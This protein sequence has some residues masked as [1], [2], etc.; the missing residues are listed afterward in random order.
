M[1]V[2]GDEKV[3]DFLSNRSSVAKRKELSQ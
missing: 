2:L 3:E 1:F